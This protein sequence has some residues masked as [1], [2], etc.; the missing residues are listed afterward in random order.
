MG[1]RATLGGNLA[2]ASPIGDWAAVLLAL[3]AS[4]VMESVDG[5]RTVPLNE[6]CVG[7][8]K[9]A[10]RPGE[11]IREILI[12]RTGSQAGLSQEFTRFYKVSRRREMD[13]S[14]VSGCFRIQLDAV[15]KVGLARVAYGGVA[16]TPVRAADVE[17]ALLGKEGNRDTIADISRSLAK[18]F[19]PIFDV[20]GSADFCA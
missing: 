8:R 5:T 3:D 17:A 18:R 15:G 20:R 19:T 9:T 13:I 7:Y 2:S 14:T 12:P 11:I 10:L 16:P 4:I 6:F 1:I